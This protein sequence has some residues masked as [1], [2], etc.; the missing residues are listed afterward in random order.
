MLVASI[1]ALIRLNTALAVTLFPYLVMTTNYHMKL[2]RIF[3]LLLIT[4]LVAACVPKID[5]GA[6][7]TAFWESLPS[8]TPI[9]SDTPF[10]SDTPTPKLSHAPSLSPSSTW[11]VVPSETPTETVTPTLALTARLI[12]PRANFGPQHVTWRSE[13]C[14]QEGNNLSCEVEYRTDEHLNCYVGMTCY[15]ACGW[16]YSVNTIPDHVGPNY[17]SSPCW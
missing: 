5:Y 13:S 16:F 9:P 2:K 14:P 7:Y 3:L 15:D 12:W 8:D 4:L 10:P 17:G 1:M 6:T 11:T